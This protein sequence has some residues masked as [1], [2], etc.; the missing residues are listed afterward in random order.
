MRIIDFGMAG[1]ANFQKYQ[2]RTNCG[3]SH[4]MAPEIKAGEKYNEK[5]DIWSTGVILYEHLNN[6]SRLYK[7][8]GNSN[9]IKIT[10]EIINKYI[11]D[12]E[13]EV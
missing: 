10:Q 2:T 5:V 13:L 4:F 11:R 9:T 7:H 1:I 8:Y 3:S 12:L 6:G